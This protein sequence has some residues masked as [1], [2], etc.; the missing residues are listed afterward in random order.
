MPFAQIRDIRMYYERQG[1]GPR[2]LYISGTGGDLRAGRV[3]EGP[4]AAWFDMRQRVRY[5]ITHQFQ[6]ITPWRLSMT[7]LNRDYISTSV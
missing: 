4:L 1:S 3:F 7:V 6:Q 5:I 2:L